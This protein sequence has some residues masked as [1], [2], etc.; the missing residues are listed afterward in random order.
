M[1]IT[2]AII[3]EQLGA[4]FDGDPSVVITGLAPLETAKAGEVSFYQ[5]PRYQGAL[6]KT[7]AS[8]I[9]LMP[10][11]KAQCPVSTLLVSEPLK[12]FA[13]LAVMFDRT[14][15]YKPGIHQSVATGKDCTIPASAS[16]GAHSVLGDNVVL[17]ENVCIEPGCYVGDRAVLGA[18]TRLRPHASVY[19]DVQLGER[20]TVHTGAV[21][22]SDGFGNV[23]TADG[24]QKIPQ[25]GGVIIGDDSDIGTNTTIDRGTLVDTRIGRGVKIDNLVQIAHNVVIGDH[26]AIAACVAVAGSTTIGKH[27][28][29]AG[30]AGITG[31]I[32]ICDNVILTG[33]AMVTKS[34]TTPGVY[35]SGTGFM[36]N[37]SW[38]RN[39]A[40]FRQLDKWIKQLQQLLKERA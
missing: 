2:L 34:I 36:D 11:E 17:G 31:H 30:T 40:R 14:P 16:I 27:C 25:L 1:A 7:K 3:A 12:A 21:I 39:A 29:I 20:V 19:H 4:E 24:W 33:M 26:T 18:G 13:Q 22:G 9:L 28:M 35:S 15:Q 10:S 23:K 37:K 6:T 8:A 38:R 5:D 32:S